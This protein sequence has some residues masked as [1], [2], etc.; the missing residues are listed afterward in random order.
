MRRAETV[1]CLVVLLLGVHVVQQSMEFPYLEKYGPGPGFLPFWLGWAWIALSLLHFSNMMLQPRLVSGRQPFP[2]GRS[3]Y[4]LAL[5]YAIVLG[6]VFLL[7]SLGLL[8]AITLMVAGLLL[9]VER[10]SWRASIVGSLAVAIP[11]Y[12]IFRVLLGIPFPKGPLG[13]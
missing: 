11:L 10:M 6:G 3:A 12:V 9:W 13:M 4:R 2:T 5:L 7:G 8:I 1:G